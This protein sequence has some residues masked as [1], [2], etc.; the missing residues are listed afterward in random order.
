M[1]LTKIE[2][3]LLDPARPEMVFTRQLLLTVWGGDWFGDDH[4]VSVHIANLRKKIDH[5]GHNH[6]TT[7][8]GVGY[9][10]TP[11]SAL[12]SQQ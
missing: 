12:P 2:F 9:R 4:L 11:T 7:V 8:R 1:E 6:V 3:D 10:L 5:N